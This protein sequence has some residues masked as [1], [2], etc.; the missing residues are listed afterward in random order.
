[1]HEPAASGED[2][3]RAVAKAALVV[4]N[5]TL[6]GGA[7]GRQ[8][9]APDDPGRRSMLQCGDGLQVHILERVS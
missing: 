8:I 3:S 5:R 6:R 2:R 4:A 7:S 9:E 1:M